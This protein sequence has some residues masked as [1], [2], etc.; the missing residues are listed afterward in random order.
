MAGQFYPVHGVGAGSY[1]LGFQRF[2]GPAGR[3]FPSQHAA[4][5]IF[6][7]HVVDHEKAAG[8]LPFQRH[9]AAVRLA[10]DQEKVSF[11]FRFYEEAFLVRCFLAS[12]EFPVLQ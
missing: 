5:V 8:L 10:L 4:E 12:L 2:F 3:H 11:L 1:G 9:G 6:H 7:V